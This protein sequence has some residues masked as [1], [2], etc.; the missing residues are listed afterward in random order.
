MHAL[1]FF[2]IFWSNFYVQGSTLEL[3]ALAKSVSSVFP[4]SIK[5]ALYCFDIL[6]VVLL[7]YFYSSGIHMIPVS[8]FTS[9]TG[10]SEQ[11]H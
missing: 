5:N 9:L 10:T 11:I 7:L 4:R 1:R 8:N 6:G 3:R 2:S